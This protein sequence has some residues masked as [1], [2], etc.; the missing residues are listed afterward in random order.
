MS[1]KKKHPQSASSPARKQP[2]IPAA[3]LNSFLGRDALGAYITSPTSFPTTRV[4]SYDEEF[5]SIRDL[6]PKSSIH[7]LLLPRDMGKAL[8]HPFD[9]FEDI[10]FLARTRTAAA[11][12]AKLVASELRRNYSSISKSSA[13][14][15]AAMQAD[16]PP[17]VLPEGRDWE[18]EV[19]VGVHAHPSMSHLHV[20]VLSRDRVSECMRHRKHYNSF[21]TPFLVPLEDMPLAK[22]DARRHPGRE[23]YLDRDLQCWRCGK[24]FGRSFAK[25]KQHLL[26]EIE[27]WKRE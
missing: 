17:E 7:L 4:L 24:N 26:E 16:P 3:D 10:E 9:A 14:R 21:A 19:L 1:P 15:E 11:I 5:V 12:L 6:Y 27:D 2:T 22:D 23:G 18:K 25:L 20:H 13:A 8:Q